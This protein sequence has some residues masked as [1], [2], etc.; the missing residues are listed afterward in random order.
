MIIDKKFVLSIMSDFLLIN[1]LV[2][3]PQVDMKFP[4]DVHH[5]FELR[6][7]L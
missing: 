4:L 3:K 7:F 5:Y 1:S 6:P 2:P